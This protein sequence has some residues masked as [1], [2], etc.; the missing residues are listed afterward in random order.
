MPPVV[1]TAASGHVGVVVV[2]DMCACVHA[3]VCARSWVRV[4]VCLCV[5]TY[6]MYE[7]TSRLVEAL[8]NNLYCDLVPLLVTQLSTSLPVP[9]AWLLSGPWSIQACLGT[10]LLL[11]LS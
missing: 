6:I 11:T 4:C 8:L 5:C 1:W 10:A 9:V 7:H 2:M 3:L